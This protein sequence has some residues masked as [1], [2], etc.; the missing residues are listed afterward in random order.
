MWVMCVCMSVVPLVVAARLPSPQI[1]A[2]FCIIQMPDLY[3]VAMSAP[4]CEQQVVK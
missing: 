4:L 2:G 3:L 1:V